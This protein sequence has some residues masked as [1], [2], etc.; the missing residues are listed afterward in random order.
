MTIAL[1]NA[2]C[3]YFISVIVTKLLTSS[4]L[5][6]TPLTIFLGV[7]SIV[8][9]AATAWTWSTQPLPTVLAM[10]LFYAAV[11]EFHLIVTT[12]VMTSISA[13]LLM[14]LRVQSLPMNQ[15]EQL[16]NERDMVDLRLQ[17]L[18][19]QGFIEQLSENR[20]AITRKGRRLHMLLGTIRTWFH[21]A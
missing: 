4:L 19:S 20:F 13:S 18:M 1:L 10:A 21:T 15:L 16:Y 2:L 6:A 11:C 12:I 7:G 9:I 3:A 17:R 14:R 5:S 8:G